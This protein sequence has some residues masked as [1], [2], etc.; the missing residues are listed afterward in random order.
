MSHSSKITKTTFLNKKFITLT[1]WITWTLSYT[2]KK[3]QDRAKTLYCGKSP[4]RLVGLSYRNNFQHFLPADVTVAIQIIHGESPPQLL[5]QLASGRDG[6]GT[7]K[8]PKVYGSISIGIEGPEHMLSELLERV[9]D[10]ELH[11]IQSN[12]V[13]MAPFYSF[14]SLLFIWVLISLFR[15]QLIGSRCFK[16]EREHQNKVHH[17]NATMVN[18][19]C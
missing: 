18:L 4:M 1:N 10:E 16:P 6:E 19:P 7:Q 11:I 14:L 2:L 17:P 9:S 5:L 15:L 12:L 8:L 3:L 13:W